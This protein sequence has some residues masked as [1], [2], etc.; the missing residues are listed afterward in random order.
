M[1]PV[2]DVARYIVN[3]SNKKDYDI[4]NLRLQ[5]LLY[6]VQAYYLAFT[7]EHKP[8]FKE[9]I[10][11]WDFGP[12]VPVAYQEFKQYGSNN[13]P[14]ITNYF[15]VRN[16]NIWTAEKQVFSENAIPPRDKKIIESVVDQ[17][18]DYSTTS[19]VSITHSQDPWLNAYVPYY[20]NEITQESI[21]EYFVQ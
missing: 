4:S 15:N 13:I 8:C 2:I 10:E 1:L 6:F 19:L 3:Y 21:R 20:N 17:F 7:D 9:K 11:A 14:A 18:S 16:K 5:K 12:V